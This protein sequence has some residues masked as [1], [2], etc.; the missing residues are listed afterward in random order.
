MAIRE[1]HPC[2]CS[3]TC[4]ETTRKSFA[5][6]HDA[7]M[8]SRLAV[9]VIIEDLT[10][11]QAARRV[12]EAGGKRALIGKLIGRVA[13]APM[14]W[15]RV[16]PG[17]ILS[18]GDDLVIQYYAVRTQRGLPPWVLHRTTDIGDE[19]MDLPERHPARHRAFWSVGEAV[20]WQAR[21]QTGTGGSRWYS[22]QTGTG[23]QP[24]DPDTL[25]SNWEWMK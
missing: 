4:R 10:I 3:P 14:R 1:P 13:A 7:R 15:T 6:G 8:V 20:A 5:P 12:Y 11:E 9:L 19:P 16:T 21:Q 2:A 22:W 25:M 24:V 17:T 18:A 23:R